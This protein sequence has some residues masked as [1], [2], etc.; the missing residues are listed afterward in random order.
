MQSKLAS[1]EPRRSADRRPARTVENPQQRPF[2][3]QRDACRR[4]E[5]RGKERGCLR[6]AAS[7]GDRDGALSDRRHKVVGI[8]NRCEPVGKAEP[9]Q[10][11]EREKRRIDFAAHDLVEACL[12]IAAQKRD[13]KIGA[14]AFHHRSAP[15]R[16]RADNG[17]LRQVAGAVRFSGNPGI[18]N[19]F[20]RQIADDADLIRQDRW[21]IL[22]RMDGD[23][24]V[25]FEESAIELL[26]EK[27][28]AARLGQRPVLNPVACRADDFDLEMCGV[29]MVRR[30]ETLAQFMRLRKCEA[31]ATG[32]DPERRNNIFWE[33]RSDGLESC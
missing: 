24:D 32:A 33:R 27:A 12:H 9:F 17:T 23:V 4:I 11:G 5:N 1:I 28:L 22:R 3:F 13:G 6:I 16:C 15:Q 31:A 29:E 30:R 2:A 26:R 21:Q 8:E 10:A 25:A 20:T 14:Q 18:A 7:T 19:I